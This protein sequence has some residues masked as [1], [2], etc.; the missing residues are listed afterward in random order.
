LSKAGRKKLKK[1]GL[2][3]GQVGQALAARSSKGAAAQSESEALFRAGARD[4]AGVIVSRGLDSDEEEDSHVAAARASKNAKRKALMHGAGG[5]GGL[6][7]GSYR[8][9]AH[10]IQAVPT[11]YDAEASR[12]MSLRGTR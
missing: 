10:F 12:H 2:G 4:A 7:S 3:A 1:T 5:P 9:A 6:T 8:D 11:G